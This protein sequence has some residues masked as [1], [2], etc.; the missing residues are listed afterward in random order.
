MKLIAAVKLLPSK[1]QEIVLK[2]T[3]ARCNEAATWLAQVGHDVGKFRQFD[4]HKLAYAD[5]RSRFGL[6]A[7]MA[8][9]TI[10]K[11]A[12]AFKVN[13]EVAPVFRKYA[14][15]PYDDRIFRF[16]KDGS[17]ASIWTLEGRIT[18]P[19]VMGEHQRRLFAYQKGEVD[20][21]FVRGKWYLAA[22]CD[23]PETTEFKAEDWLGVDL[24][25]VHL[26]ADSDGTTYTGS[27]V[28]AV[29]SRLARRKAGLQRR[30][31]KAA[32]RKLKKLA[33]KEARFRQHT[34]HVI[35]KAIVL[36]A[37][38]TERGLALEELTHIR[39]RVTARKSQRSRLHSWAFGQLRAFVAYKAKRAGVPVVYVDPRNTSREC[40]CCG[41]IDKANRRDQ[42]TFHC[43]GCGF[44]ANADTNAAVNIRKRALMA[45]GVVMSPEVLAA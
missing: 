45:R 5:I 13:R 43:I 4:L 16:V 20:L 14:A 9:R 1:H 28:E 17:E 40:P 31:T 10:A 23:I 25:I 41:F 27:A 2:Q 3:L 22:T 6:A 21:C 39:A 7:Q 35:A 29:R 36:A 34:N 11:V 44:Q 33:G 18:V 32:K 37:E 24:G 38:R 19:C 15:Q 42:A 26:A 8:V 12:D 30:G